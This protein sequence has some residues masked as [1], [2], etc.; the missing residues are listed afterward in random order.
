M[1]KWDSAKLDAVASDYTYRK[2]GQ[3]SRIIDIMASKGFLTYSG[4]KDLTDNLNLHLESAS[5]LLFII[6][7]GIRTNVQQLADFLNSNT[8]MA[9]NLALAEI[10]VYERGDETIVI[11]QLVTK[12]TI[13]DRNIVPFTPVLDE[14]RKWKYVSGPILSRGEFI[15][16]FSENGGFDPDQITELVFSLEAVTGLSVRIT[17]TELTLQ[18]SLPGGKSFALLTFSIAD[19]H[20]DIWVMPGRLKAALEKAGIFKFEADPFLDAYKPF[21]DMRRCKT[22]PYEY[23]AG[24]YYA[25]IDLVI[26]KEREFVSAVERFA[27]SVSKSDVEV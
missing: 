21:V 19:G 8:S 20:A 25:D 26:A 6:G 3:A 22:P 16:R 12:T 5:F 4:E 10:E 18:L 13:I 2:T 7:D 9:F 27:F 14:P 11:P 15:A 17:A 23:E 24:F 1:Q